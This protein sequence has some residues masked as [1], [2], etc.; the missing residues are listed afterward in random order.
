MKDRTK[1][2]YA[3]QLIE[4][5]K[6]KPLHKITVREICKACNA[7]PQNFYYHFR[8]KYDLVTWVY[9]QDVEAVCDAHMDQSWSEVLQICFENLQAR[10]S[11][12]RNAC[13]D[14]SGYSVIRYIVEYQVDLYTRILIKK[15]LYIDEDL[16]FIIM[17]HAYACAHITRDWF[18]A[19]KPV[20]PEKLTTQIMEAMPDR[21]RKPLEQT[22]HIPEE[23]TKGANRKS[24]I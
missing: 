8:D 23:Q 22:N 9:S 6:H 15:G 10:Q 24:G 20:S 19:R 12:Y 17:Y 13:A 16:A 14:D 18:A 1:W 3:N 7:Q 5:M 2:E 4:L 21:L 11:F